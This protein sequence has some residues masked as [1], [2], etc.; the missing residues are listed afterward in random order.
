[1]RIT[2]ATGTGAPLLKPLVVTTAL[3]A[4]GM[5]PV[6]PVT[7]RVVAVEAVTVPVPGQPDVQALSPALANPWATPP[8]FGPL[9]PKLDGLLDQHR[10]RIVHPV[11]A[12]PPAPTGRGPLTQGAAPLARV[13]LGCA[14]DEALAQALRDA[15]AAIAVRAVRAARAGVRHRPTSRTRN[16]SMTAPA[17]NPWPRAASLP[18][19]GGGSSQRSEDGDG[20]ATLSSTCSGRVAFI[21]RP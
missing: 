12:A 13:C 1:M 11:P 2:V 9:G 10:M 20:L 5:C 8:G 4:P 7:V 6:R 3:N 16:R 21:T 19:S 17:R 14:P 15:L 18:R